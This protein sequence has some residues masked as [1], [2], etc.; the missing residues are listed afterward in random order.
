MFKKEL[1]LVAFLEQETYAFF[2]PGFPLQ[3]KFTELQ[4][5]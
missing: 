5:K 4:L 3:M 2:I 1:P